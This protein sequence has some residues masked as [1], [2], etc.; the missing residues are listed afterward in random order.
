M[1][2][3]YNVRS[4]S[5]SGFSLIEMLIVLAI[6]GTLVGLA[7]YGFKYIEQAKEK[8][9]V[10]NLKAVKDAIDNY[11]HRTGQYPQK[12]N[13]LVVKPASI[14]SKR[15]WGGS[16]FG[17]EDEPEDVPQDSWDNDFVYKFL[18]GAHPPY[19][20]YSWGKNGPGSPEDEWY[21]PN[22]KIK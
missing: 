18:E 8:T 5:R 17:R 4:T 22:T 9:T 19:K 14:E 20:L 2:V 10:A 3:S 16:Y 7:T 11:K 21:Y 12:L 6:M 15:T 1:S 13:D